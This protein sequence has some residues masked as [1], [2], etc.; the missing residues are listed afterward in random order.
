[1]RIFLILISA[2]LCACGNS[3]LGAERNQLNGQFKGVTHTNSSSG[4]TTTGSSQSYQFGPCKNL[5]VY[6]GSD[7]S[8]A[9]LYSGT[10]A[11][12]ATNNQAVVKVRLNASFPTSVRVCIVPSN[13]Q[14]SYLATCVVINGQADVYLGTTNFDAI[15]VVRETD[16]NQYNSFLLTG[17]GNPPMAYGL[18]R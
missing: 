17:A 16:L 8:F 15:T 2:M 11:C 13:S 6:N 7:S 1:M 10:S 18:V 9:Q 4:G 3:D 14:Q 5:A 12:P